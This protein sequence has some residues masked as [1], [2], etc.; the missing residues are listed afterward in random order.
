MMRMMKMKKN[1]DLTR[2]ENE[3]DETVGSAKKE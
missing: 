3:E 1:N 2:D